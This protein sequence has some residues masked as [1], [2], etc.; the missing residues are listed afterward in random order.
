M[1]LFNVIVFTL[2]STKL[3]VLTQYYYSTTNH[4]LIYNCINANALLNKQL[5]HIQLLICNNL[6]GIRVCKHRQIVRYPVIFE[7]G[8]SFRLHTLLRGDAKHFSEKLFRLGLL[9]TKTVQLSCLSKIEFNCILLKITFTLSSMC[10]RSRQSVI[11][12]LL[13]RE[14]YYSCSRA[15]TSFSIV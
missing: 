7:S 8:D 12:L 5:D 1:L 2:V 4:L 13:D 9:V 6:V 3:V 15:N 10:S 11:D 14:S